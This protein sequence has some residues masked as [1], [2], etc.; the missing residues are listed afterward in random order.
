[1]KE[2]RSSVERGLTRESVPDNLFVGYDL[3]MMQ[4]EMASG[5][6]MGEDAVQAVAWLKT[7]GEE[8]QISIEDRFIDDLMMKGGKEKRRTWIPYLEAIIG[9]IGVKPYG[10]PSKRK[11]FRITNPGIRLEP[12]A[13]GRDKK[14][15]GVVRF[16]VDKLDIKD[17]TPEDGNVSLAEH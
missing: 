3:D 2:I 13:T 15:H 17:M 10:D 6:E 9:T 5:I 11:V 16:C 7:I 1:M 12:R 14:F 4:K 8:P